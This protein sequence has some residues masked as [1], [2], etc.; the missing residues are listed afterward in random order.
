MTLIEYCLILEIL[1]D[2]GLFT[3]GGDYG[4][5][6][7]ISVG[8]N[9]VM[10][11]HNGKVNAFGKIPLIAL[12]SDCSYYVDD[13]IKNDQYY[14]KMAIDHLSL[15]EL[16]YEKRLRRTI[17][18]P[19]NDDRIDEKP[20]LNNGKDKSLSQCSF[21]S[22]E[23]LIRFIIILRNYYN[24]VSLDQTNIDREVENTLQKVIIEQ[25][26]IGRV[27]ISIEEWITWRPEIQKIHFE[28]NLEP[29]KL[30]V[31]ENLKNVLNSFTKV[32]NPF[33]GDD[34]DEN[35]VANL[36]ANTDVEVRRLVA[37]KQILH[38]PNVAVDISAHNIDENTL[39]K[40]RYERIE[41]GIVYRFD[42][43]VYSSDGNVIEKS[44]FFVRYEK[45]TGCQ[46]VYV[47]HESLGTTINNIIYFDRFNHY[48]DEY[49]IKV[50]SDIELAIQE[51]EELTLK[52]MMTK[53]SKYRRK[54]IPLN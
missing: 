27:G 53:D 13:I 7:N 4:D 35:S 36:I 37:S 19:Y 15:T 46:I 30:K 24:N 50:I 18:I 42:K 31:F 12:E 6:K 9:M 49:I 47:S 14:K 43:E 29:S 2:T 28:K 5:I 3:P 54:K 32:V 33:A 40:C 22:K 34:A 45:S 10:F 16:P 26:K 21:E 23:E 1:K 20:D 39:V 17:N 48:S 38:Y 52:N 44:C 51:A 11:Y 25:L 8:K 41:D